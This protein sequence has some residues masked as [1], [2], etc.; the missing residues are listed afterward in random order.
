MRLTFLTKYALRSW[1]NVGV[2]VDVERQHDAV[3]L[4]LH[5]RMLSPD[6]NLLIL[7]ERDTG[8][9]EHYLIERCRLPCG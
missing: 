9:L 7:I 2:G 5:A 1:V 8:H 4:V 3:Y 6:V